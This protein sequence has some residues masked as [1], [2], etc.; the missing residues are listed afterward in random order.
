MI[1]AQ[2][3]LKKNTSSGWMIGPEMTVA[4]LATYGRVLSF[5][6]RRYDNI[7]ADL[8]DQFPLVNGAAALA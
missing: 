6:A 1:C 8:L 5:K 4:D 3:L 2:N 7:P